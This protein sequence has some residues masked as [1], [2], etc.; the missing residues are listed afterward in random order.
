MF[1]VTRLKPCHV[2]DG[3]VQHQVS[4]PLA[5]VYTTTLANFSTKR[6][7]LDEYDVYE[8]TANPN[9]VP[10]DFVRVPIHLQS[11]GELVETIATAGRLR[12]GNA[13]FWKR[14]SA[15]VRDLMSA[16][17]VKE[18]VTI[19]NAYA[20]ARY[21]DVDLL[22]DVA[23]YVTL[24]AYDCRVS[25]IA[26][27]LQA[28]ARLSLLNK[29]LFELLGLQC[30]HRIEE[31]GPRGVATIASSFGGVRLPHPRL[32]AAISN[33]VISQAESYSCLDL[34]QVLWAFSQVEYR[35]TEA[36]ER[37]AAQLVLRIRTCSVLEALTAAQACSQLQYR[38][39]EL[40]DTLLAFFLQNIREVRLQYLPAVITVFSAFD[41]IG[42]SCEHGRDVL[43]KT[44]SGA[45]L[46]L[47]AG[48][49]VAQNASWFSVD[50]L[51]SAAGALRS[52][53]LEH[54]HL[55]VALR[56]LVP[57]RVAQLT[58]EECVD[59]LQSA[60][61][62]GADNCDPVVFEALKRLFSDAENPE[63]VDPLKLSDLSVLRLLQCFYD[64]K[65]L[66][67]LAA[68]FELA[69]P[70]VASRR[71]AG[72]VEG[73]TPSLPSNGASRRLPFPEVLVA[74]RVMLQAFNSEGISTDELNATCGFR[75]C[76]VP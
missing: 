37:I 75:W 27:C 61:S 46:Y 41:R 17:R 72:L 35:N 29:P 32:F 26:V 18:L 7:R 70:E 14:C 55:T 44:L 64:L 60:A 39:G 50:E 54:E 48:Q 8:A 67:A 49:R 52:I 15:A 63:W 73:E 25:D 38:H 9:V 59:I 20:K 53:G 36:M 43:H 5:A 16:F 62:R 42:D 6:V 76:G 71:K 1:L 22:D 56:Q 69:F 33:H 68:S 40:V 28:F 57:L 2:S 10:S 21:C 74:Q 65:R 3:F 51:A 4:R 58:T 45:S 11:A 66:D 24:L 30:L 12:L 23:K 47:A 13:N 34:V 19:V 31:L